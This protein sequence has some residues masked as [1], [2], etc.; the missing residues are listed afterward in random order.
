VTPELPRR[1]VL[2][3]LGA[4]P[5]AALGLSGSALGVDEPT[6]T[7]ETTGWSQF[8]AGPGR[9]G[10]VDGAAALDDPFA[11]E[12]WVA[13]VDDHVFVD[14]AIVAD[15]TVYLPFIHDDL[16]FRGGVI[17][18]DAESG[19]ER[20]R[21]D[22]EQGE[23]G[24]GG[25]GSP[26][27]VGDGRLYLTSSPGVDRA[28]Y[29][30]LH[31]ID[32][33]TGELSWR[34]TDGGW[35]DAPLFAAGTLF[36]EGGPDG[37]AVNALD[38]E[39][40]EILW[41]DATASNE[42]VGV[43]D[44]LLYGVRYHSD[45]QNELVAWRCEDGEIELS[46]PVPNGLDGAAAVVVDGRIYGSRQTDDRANVVVAHDANG[47]NLWRTRLTPA[48]ELGRPL[49]S[50]PSVAGD[51]V[52]V[53]T[54]T[55]Y[56]GN[57]EAGIQS[58]LSAVDARS[59]AVRWAR[60]VSTLLLGPPTVVGDTVY[61]AGETGTTGDAAVHAFATEDGTERWGYRAN[62]RYI[63]PQYART[64]T[65][66]DGRVYVVQHAR[67]A[68]G[69]ASLIALTGTDEEP[70]DSMV[71]P[72]ASGPIAVIR[73]DPEDADHRYQEY[74][75]TVTLDASASTGDVQTYEWR[76]GNLGSFEPAGPIFDVTFERCAPTDVTLRVID[77]EG[78]QDSE[79]ISFDVRDR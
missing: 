6:G 23:P 1:T 20:W 26:P 17:A 51:A 25:V 5:L 76:R 31:A 40:G 22:A 57:W 43:A 14:E 13:S 49:L 7:A 75:S 30:G 78:R 24:I 53:T 29:G 63:E 50:R 65:V 46:R 73:T 8:R 60:D 66:A 37:D 3:S 32:A 36:A 68:G 38:P 74:G 16:T 69:K 64:P 9:T 67:G 55:S 19:T 39:T 45:D 54:A 71:P 2:A 42:Y 41:R 15:G 52:Y 44:D 21:H 48:G 62:T 18:F 12:A 58:T 56:R 10:A 34:R 47:D 33:E 4:L 70:D 27:A 28:P 59:G 35:V 11:A 61:V 79:T 77:G 72:S